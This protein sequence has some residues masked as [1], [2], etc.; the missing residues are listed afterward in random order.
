MEDEFQG[1]RERKGKFFC[2]RLLRGYIGVK[3]SF[4]KSVK[5]M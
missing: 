4:L 1:S 5:G 3:V 2:R